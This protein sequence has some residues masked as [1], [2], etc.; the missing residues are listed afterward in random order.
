MRYTT[1]MLDI[2]GVGD[3]A[4]HTKFH[5]NSFIVLIVITGRN[6]RTR[7]VL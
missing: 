4:I 2:S 5:K 3:N 1:N 7:H 6:I